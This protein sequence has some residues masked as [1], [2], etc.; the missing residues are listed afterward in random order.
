MCHGTSLGPS[1]QTREG[2]EEGQ[3]SGRKRILPPLVLASPTAQVHHDVRVW[4]PLQG[5]RFL[6]L[7]GGSSPHDGRGLRGRRR[8]QAEAAGCCLPPAARDKGETQDLSRAQWAAAATREAWCPPRT[9]EV[10]GSEER[11]ACPR[12]DIPSIFHGGQVDNFFLD[13]STL[14]K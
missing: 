5:Q 8:G 3:W 2:R 13:S 6:M 10:L 12:L 1:P 14:R 9:G 7:E 11:P 4:C